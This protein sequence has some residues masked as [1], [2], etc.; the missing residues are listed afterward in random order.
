MQY[1]KRKRCTKR[2][3]T[4]QWFW[5]GMKTWFILPRGRRYCKK[6][7]RFFNRMR[8]WQLPYHP[9]KYHVSGITLWINAVPRNE[10]EAIA[11]F[12]P[13]VT[14]NWTKLYRCYDWSGLVIKVSIHNWMPYWKN[15]LKAF[16]TGCDSNSRG[17]EW[18]NRNQLDHHK[19]REYLK[20]TYKE[21]VRVSMSRLMDNV[22][23]V[24]AG[25]PAPKRLLQDGGWIRPASP[26]TGFGM[27]NPVN[28]IWN[29]LSS[30]STFQLSTLGYSDRSSF[31]YR[32]PPLLKRLRTDGRC[33]GRH[34]YW[35]PRRGLRVYQTRV[36]DRCTWTHCSKLVTTSIVFLWVHYW[37][38]S[39]SIMLRRRRESWNWLI[40]IQLARRKRT[41]PVF[42]GPAIR[43][44][45]ARQPR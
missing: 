32:K 29:W 7:A 42:Y 28:S 23:S 40:L 44:N 11:T 21:F 2:E 12:R 20:K 39:L 9:T 25:A 26:E 27:P 24:S 31:E 13:F 22:A 34:L 14:S 30:D 36:G 35:M 17:S 3:A 19:P 6:W 15:T 37:S 38:V 41:N 43:Y 16:K 8:M 18:E 33:T 45:Y 5:C 4:R 1:P 10:L